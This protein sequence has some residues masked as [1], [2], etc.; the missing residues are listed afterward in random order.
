MN[1]FSKTTHAIVAIVT[2]MAT[3]LMAAPPGLAQP[4]PTYPAK[5]IRIVTGAAGTQNDIVA[6]MLSTKMSESFGQ[7]VIVDNRGGAG[8]AIGANVVAK[9]TPDGY[10]LL[11]QSGQFAIRAAVQTNLPYDSHRDL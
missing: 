9:A 5:P 6:R 3:A 10:T 2:F 1:V 7:P 11:L 4:N 8:G